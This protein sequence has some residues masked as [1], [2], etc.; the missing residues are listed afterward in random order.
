MTDS[1]ASNT[2]TSVDS[3]KGMLIGGGIP[4]V[5]G[6]RLSEKANVAESLLT[7]GHSGGRDSRESTEPASNQI[8]VRDKLT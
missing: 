6:R 8:E 5:M 3:T 2:T 7:F 1:S 4:T